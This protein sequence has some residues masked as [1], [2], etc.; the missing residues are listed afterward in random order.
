MAS[1]E[2]LLHK[3]ANICKRNN[4]VRYLIVKTTIYSASLSICEWESQIISTLYPQNP[5]GDE[6]WHA[7]LPLQK[8]VSCTRMNHTFKVVVIAPQL[9]LLK[10]TEILPVVTVGPQ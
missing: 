6:K 3:N 7:Y 1:I 10:C 4:R 8:D 2:L 9:L 5:M